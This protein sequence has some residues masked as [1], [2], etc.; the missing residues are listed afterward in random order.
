MGA[1]YKDY[2]KEVD[3]MKELYTKEVGHGVCRAGSHKGTHG[4]VSEPVLVFKAAP[5]ST[6]LDNPR[7]RGR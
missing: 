6:L 2:A 7:L 3:L 4:N 5:D 1:S